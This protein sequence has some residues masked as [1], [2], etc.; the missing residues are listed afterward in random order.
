[1][2]SHSSPKRDINSHLSDI[3]SQFQELAK[4]CEKEGTTENDRARM[5]YLI[6]EMNKIRSKFNY[7]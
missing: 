1:M 5:L 4:K 3:E 7:T 2:R 6:Q